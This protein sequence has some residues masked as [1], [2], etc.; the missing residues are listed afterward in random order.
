M[1]KLVGYGL[2]KPV[3]AGEMGYMLGVCLKTKLFHQTEASPETKSSNYY[4]HSV[5]KICLK[6]NIK[7]FYYLIYY[8]FQISR[9]EKKFASSRNFSSTKI[10]LPLKKIS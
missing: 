10:P 9:D 4:Y 6:T 1:G 7:L 3:L 8:F 5:F 2:R